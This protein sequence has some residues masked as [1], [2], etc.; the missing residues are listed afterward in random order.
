MDLLPTFARLAGTEPPS[1]RI[2]D[3]HNIWPLMADHAEASSPYDAFYYYYIG[4]LQ[5]VRS[6]KWKLHLP[7]KAKWRNFRGET[8]T[9]EAALYDLE[10]DVGETKNLAG[11]YPDILRHLMAL[12][13]NAR[14][15]LGDVDQPG[16][17]QRP[18][19]F[20]VNPTPRVLRQ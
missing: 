15:D 19:G 17:H 12:A 11:K 18:A 10:A 9:S 20:V 14:A 1:D 6:G 5:A 16:T 7:L 13:E 4:Q 3:G 2:I 8:V